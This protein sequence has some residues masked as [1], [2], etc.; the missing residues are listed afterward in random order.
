MF[1]IQHTNYIRFVLAI[2]FL[3]SC[4]F[5]ENRSQ[6]YSST[7]NNKKSKEDNLQEIEKKKVIDSSVWDCYSYEIDNRYNQEYDKEYAEEFSKFA[8]FTLKNDSIFIGD[9]KEA[10]YTYEFPVKLKKHDEES[11]FTTYF[12][13]KTKNI[14]II[15]SKQ[16]RNNESCAPIDNLFIYKKNDN[17]L[18]I[19]DRGYFFHFHK[20][21][22]LVKYDIKVDDIVGIPGNNRNAWRVETSLKNIPDFE[23]AYSYFIK[24]FPYGARGMS[25]SIPN[26]KEFVDN[27]NNIIYNK[28]ADSLI[29]SKSDPMGEII[30]SFRKQ[31]K[32]ILFL[33]KL[34]YPDYD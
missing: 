10:V 25:I 32:G 16:A 4:N 17:E 18:I 5:K 8:Y 6:T 22:L 7:S 15:S 14:Q 33:Y 27:K 23:Q 11:V 31:K 20:R 21:N 30:V 13:P 12:K 1:M 29:I 24:S 28:Y 2:F 9:C 34:K 19:H 3:I 26:N